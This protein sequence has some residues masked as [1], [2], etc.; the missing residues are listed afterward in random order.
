MS[1]W[2]ERRK[3]IQYAQQQNDQIKHDK[4]ITNTLVDVR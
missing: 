2:Q 1:L 4:T 3:T